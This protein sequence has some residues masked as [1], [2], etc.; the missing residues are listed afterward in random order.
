DP[1]RPPLPCRASPPRGGRS[2]VAAAFANL[3]RC[4]RERERPSCQSPPVW[5]RCPA[6][7]RGAL[8]RPRFGHY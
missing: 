5:G 1:S 4:R 3:Q 7:Q 6:G 2:D 8:S